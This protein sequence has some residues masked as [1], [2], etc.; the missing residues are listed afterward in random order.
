MGLEKTSHD[1]A[2]ETLHDVRSP[3]RYRLI[4]EAKVDDMEKRDVGVSPDAFLVEFFD[5]VNDRIEIPL[6]V[7]ST[8]VYGVMIRSAKNFDYRLPKPN[9]E[10]GISVKEMN[11]TYRSLSAK[12]AYEG[13]SDTFLNPMSYLV[14]RRPDHI[15]DAMIV[16]EE[17]LGKR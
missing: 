3:K 2:I 10:R 6:S 8:I 15:M 4:L 12:M 14:K 9:T 11:L 1:F 13:H 5:L 16:P 17:V 7:L